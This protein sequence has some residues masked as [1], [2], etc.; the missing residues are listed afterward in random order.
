MDDTKNVVLF[1]CKDT[2]IRNLAAQLV[3]SGIP[4]WIALRQATQIV[5]AK[6]TI[7][8]SQHDNR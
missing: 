1:Q 7:D 6:V 5:D 4:S 8:E 3:R 2:E